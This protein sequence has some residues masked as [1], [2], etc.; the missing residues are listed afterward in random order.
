MNKYEVQEIIGEGINKLLS[1]RD[2]YNELVLFLLGTYGVVV[3]AL[4][5]VSSKSI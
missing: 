5:K 3:K 4:N 1:N 2:V